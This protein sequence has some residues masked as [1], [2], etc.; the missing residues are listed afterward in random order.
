M[1]ILLFVLSLLMAH[2]LA[3]QERPAIPFEC[4]CALGQNGETYHVKLT[5]QYE[6]G[7]AIIHFTKSGQ[8]SPAKK[9]QVDGTLDAFQYGGNGLVFEFLYPG[10]HTLVFSED[11]GNIQKVFDCSSSF[12]VL[13]AGKYA[14][15]FAGKRILEDGTVIP[16]T[17]A[18]YDGT[19]H[20]YK[21]VSTVPF[22]MTYVELSKLIPK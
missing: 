18:I 15:C 9:I 11:N 12:G 2:F 1:R 8:S 3:A 5:Q 20:P 6:P 22:A 7:R 14:V 21:Q 17:A 19:V 10:P 4:N 13:F 16:E